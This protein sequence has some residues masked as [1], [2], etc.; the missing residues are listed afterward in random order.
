MRNALFIAALAVASPAAFSQSPQPTAPTSPTAPYTLKAGTQRVLVDVIVKDKKGNVIHGLKRS[1]FSITENKMPQPIRSFDEHASL[2]DAQAAAT[3]HPPA[4]PP[5]EFSNFV[6]VPPNSALNV[7]LFDKLNTSVADQQYV[8]S[9]LIN[10]LKHARPDSRTAIFGLNDRLVL[11]SG[12]QTDPAA[13]LKALET[14]GTPKGSPLRNDA[15]GH[16]GAEDF[17]D[18][19]AALSRAGISI[20][21]VQAF[22]AQDQAFQAQIRSKYTLDALNQIGRSLAPL[23]GRKNLIWFTGNFPTNLFPGDNDTDIPYAQFAGL[24]QEFRDT[25]NLLTNAQI[26]IYPVDAQGLRT[27]NNNEASA[28]NAQYG[29]AKAGESRRGLNSAVDLANDSAAIGIEHIG[30]AQIAH[31]TGGEA[32]YNSSD[33]VKAVDNAISSGS[34]YY[35]VAYAPT[36]TS[37][38]PVFRSIK[39]TANNSDYRLSYRRG[40]YADQSAPSAETRKQI[41]G[42][43]PPPNTALRQ[44]LMQGA[45]QP[46][47]ILLRVKTAPTDAGGDQA[48]AAGNTPNPDASRNNPPFQNFGVSF[49]ASARAVSLRRTSDNRYHADLDFITY[50]YDSRGV[51]IN[52]QS[53]TIRSDYSPQEVL[54]ILRGGIHFN[55]TVSVPQSGEHYL[56]MAVH[57]NL[58]DKVGAVEVP[59]SL[60]KSLPIPMQPA[61]TATPP[62]T[63]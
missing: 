11:L 35:T 54:E 58:G 60:I 20:A 13:L 59:V 5:G 10:Y 33:L 57:D 53:N 6:A 25:I 3:P 16:A 38:K 28:S 8:R 47:E 61:A 51:L 12:F 26:A 62:A 56:R 36:N 48:V 49:A 41:S 21:A 23:P 39:I 34:N 19:E 46:T 30:M 4:L 14:K 52:A 63:H 22:D 45:P 24:E 7:I 43:A 42:N 2:T 40:Y 9:Q 31:D 44:A 37:A 55:Q 29:D 17:S 1:D 27:N 50:V 32:F 18:L 15:F